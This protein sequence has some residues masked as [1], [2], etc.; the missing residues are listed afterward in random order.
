MPIT[1]LSVG[2]GLLALMIDSNISI[3][4]NLMQMVQNYLLKNRLIHVAIENQPVLR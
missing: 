4:L 1:A 3:V 2:N